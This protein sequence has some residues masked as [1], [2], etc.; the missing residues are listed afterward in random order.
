MT[1][2][3]CSVGSF[4]VGNHCTRTSFI[5]LKP[6]ETSCDICTRWY[7][8]WPDKI[9]DEKYASICRKAFNWFKLI[10]KMASNQTCSIMTQDKKDT[11]V[12]GL[13]VLTNSLHSFSSCLL[14]FLHCFLIVL[15]CVLFL[16]LVSGYLSP[17][18]PSACLSVV[19]FLGLFPLC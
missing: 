6:Y 14:W 3:T 8:I 18:V 2:K 13:L 15:T 1:W 4:V 9:Q 16:S 17:C 19:Y 10:A 5:F 7:I 11:L 12:F